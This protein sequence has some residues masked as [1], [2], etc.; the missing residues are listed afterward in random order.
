[1]SEPILFSRLAQQEGII[2]RRFFPHDQ[3]VLG[4]NALLID[5]S[6]GAEGKPGFICVPKES[7][8]TVPEKA[9]WYGL[10]LNRIHQPF[11]LANLTEFGVEGFSGY[12]FQLGMF[13]QFQFCVASVGNLTKWLVGRDTITGMD[14][15]RAMNELIFG[16]VQQTMYALLG[17]LP[18]YTQIVE[19]KA[20]LEAM[21]EKRL[22][23]TFLENGLCILPGSFS[24]IN[25]SKP[26][27]K[28]IN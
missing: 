16:N 14:L 11:G 7:V 19:K 13:G 18:E 9:V 25:F 27:M 28:T 15:I 8:C 1:M 20:L 23:K 4:S 10:T 17:V 5:L 2:A 6:G 24:I 26:Y 3:F 21:T 12:R 22:F